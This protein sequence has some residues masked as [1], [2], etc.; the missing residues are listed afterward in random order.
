MAE[1]KTEEEDTSHGGTLTLFINFSEELFCLAE[2]CASSGIRMRANL[3]LHSAAT[4]PVQC[5][6]CQGVQ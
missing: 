1:S 6:V 2:G 4:S 5:T 3:L